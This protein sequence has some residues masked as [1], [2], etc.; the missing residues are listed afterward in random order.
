MNEGP[1]TRGA[2][3]VFNAGTTDW[4][5]GLDHDPLVRQVTH[6]VLTRLSRAR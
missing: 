3:T 6:N 4:S 1:F 2:G 5:Y